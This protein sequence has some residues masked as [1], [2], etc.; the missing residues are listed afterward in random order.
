[1][2]TINLL[3]GGVIVRPPDKSRREHARATYKRAIHL[4]SNGRGS[5]FDQSRILTMGRSRDASAQ[6]TYDDVCLRD[7][8]MNAQLDTRGNVRIRWYSA[9]GL[10]PSAK[11]ALFTMAHAGNSL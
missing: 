8:S 7:I 1:M 4:S 5:P 11:F 6:P 3:V 2:G 9:R 10:N